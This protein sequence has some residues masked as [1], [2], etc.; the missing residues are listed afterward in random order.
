MSKTR[1][2]TKV[3]VIRHAEKPLDPPPYGIAED[4]SRDKECLTVRG[5]QRAGAF[6][7]YFAPSEGSL[8]NSALAKPQ[9]L[10][11]SKP[12]KRRGSQRSI[13]TITPLAEKLGIKITTKYSRD[14]GKEM[15]EDAL[16][17]EGVVL[18]SWQHEYIPAI[19]NHILGD[20]TTAPQSWPEGRYDVVWVFDLDAESG[21][22]DF[23]EVPQCLL[24]G[25]AATPIK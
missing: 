22:Y 16:S 19:A 7:C 23:L 12:I 15:L 13:Q 9:F 8:Q 10:Y 21:Q 14:E 2:A 17:C 18:I 5:W 3:M 6:A 4:G 24:S 1:Q 20:T 25:D 11:A